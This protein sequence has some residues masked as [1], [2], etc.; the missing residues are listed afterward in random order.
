MG[1]QLSGKL[2]LGRSRQQ[3]SA[4]LKEALKLVRA[5]EARARPRG[6][7]AKVYAL[8]RSRLRLEIRRAL[9]SLREDEETSL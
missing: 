3:V 2:L 8:M 6:P 4:M 5:A 1:I 9:A 7:A